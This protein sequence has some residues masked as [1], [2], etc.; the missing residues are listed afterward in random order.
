MFKT[1]LGRKFVVV[2]YVITGIFALQL[3]DKALDPMLAN[4]MF[5]LLMVYIGGQ[6]YLDTKKSKQEQM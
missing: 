4:G 3:L 6:A 1:K 2:L 5:G